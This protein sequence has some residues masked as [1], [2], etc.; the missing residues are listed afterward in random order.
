MIAVYFVFFA[1]FLILVLITAIGRA[2]MFEK[3]GEKPWKA[4]IPFYGEYT[5]YRLTWS[6]LLYFVR[7]W[8]IA[9]SNLAN[10]ETSGLLAQGV[11][12]VLAITAIAIS[13]V[14]AQKTA[15][16][17]GKGTGFGIGLWLLPPLYCLIA[18]FGKDG[19]ICTLEEI[20]KIYG[21]TRERIRQIEAKA[22]RKL[23]ENADDYG[24]DEYL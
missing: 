2:K 21:V 6:K 8:L 7:L 1:I 22:L 23:R 24:L 10:P 13:A 18:S 5:L 20:G 15:R 11:A 16:S 19:K 12:L 3:A 14:S 9:L 4:F 17:Y